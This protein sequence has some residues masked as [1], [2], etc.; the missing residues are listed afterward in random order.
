MARHHDAGGG[1][2]R[3]GTWMFC[4]CGREGKDHQIRK[5]LR[6]RAGRG[7]AD[8]LRASGE[9][10]CADGGCPATRGDLAEAWSG[11]AAVAYNRQATCCNRKDDG[12]S[13][14]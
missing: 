14:D 8:Q 3:V 5:P 13:G 4:E 11:D 2:R 1:A 10:G 9:T 7:E 12:E 6:D